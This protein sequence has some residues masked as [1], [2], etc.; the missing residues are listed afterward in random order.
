MRSNRR[1][2]GGGVTR[3]TVGLVVVACQAFGLSSP[4]LNVAAASTDDD[5][6]VEP[7]D[8]EMVRRHGG[9][10]YDSAEIE[11]FFSTPLVIE[12]DPS[13]L[14]QSLLSPPPPS[15]V[16]PRVLFNPEDMPDI[17][18]RLEDTACG[19][20]VMRNIRKH[21]DKQLRD[22]T[23]PLT[24][25]YEELSIGQL[26]PPADGDPNRNGVGFLLLYECFRCLID[27][28]AT[29]GRKAAAAVATLARHVET[30]I[31][32]EIAKQKDRAARNDFRIVALGPTFEGTLGLMYDFAHG[33]MDDSQRTAVRRA[34]AKG[35]AGMTFVGCETLR[36]LT[37]NTS[38][39]SPW[40]AR[41]LFLCCAI[42]GE[43]GYDPAAYE[44]CVAAVTGNVGTIYP[45]GE[46][47]EGWGKNFMFLEHLAIVAK[48]G[49]NLLTS[50]NLRDVFRRHYIAAMDPWGGRFTFYDSISGTGSRISRN[51]DVVLY[52]HVFPDDAAGAF[53]YRNQVLEGYEALTEKDR[54]NTRHPFALT[55]P[56]ICAIYAC[57]VDCDEPWDQAMARVVEGRPLTQ[58]SE[59]TCNLITRS[60]WSPDAVF[61]SYQNRAVMGG[62]VYADRSHF[63][64]YADGRYWAIYRTLRQVK[65]HYKPG[66]RSVVMIDGQGPSTPPARCVAFTDVP[67]ATFIAT[68]LSVPWNYSSNYVE[69]TRD[70]GATV[71]LP[72]SWNHFRLHPSPL[73]C[74]ELPIEGGPNWL[75]SRKPEPLPKN[76]PP[77]VGWTARTPGIVRAYRTAGL[78]RGVRPYAVVVD[79]IQLDAE[80]HDFSWNLTIAD[81]VV[82]GKAR[83][84]GGDDWPMAELVLEEKSPP[85]DGRERR[86]L[87]RFLEARGV[88]EEPATIETVT[89]PDGWHGKPMSFP[90]LVVRS[91]AVAPNFKAVLVPLSD[92]QPPPK[93]IWNDDHTV[94][95][96]A[97]PDQADTIAFSPHR[98]GRTRLA[99]ARDGR[100][101]IDWN[102]A[103][104]GSER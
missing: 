62:H 82:L 89:L 70:R 17:R 77:F 69:P 41:M 56:L 59:D 92:G 8:M 6:L 84:V 95:T 35:S 23:S 58:F 4:S 104:G 79:D 21:L 39:W 31:E 80:V 42:E 85:P 48:R 51:A 9:F 34:V 16:H 53:C 14:N 29:G 93:T 19:R 71:A 103:A 27:D 97:W 54:I 91:K 83:R 67:E 101:V 30:R 99:V 86:L 25:Q 55:D 3:L 11:K 33:F 74:M 66:N 37:T 94:L 18:R 64:L 32:E 26:G 49:K 43:G 60:S 44:R 73:P 75:T 90:K 46:A 10:G 96:V 22:P 1:H 65:E 63:N 81:D 24:A 7:L 57:D 87:V 45:G 88:L 36:S 20:L 102:G 15:G 68:D 2:D 5:T 61:F 78:V 13:G 72:H 98:D 38:N 52:H 76:P 100:T 50:R 40:S 28:D 12:R 47:F